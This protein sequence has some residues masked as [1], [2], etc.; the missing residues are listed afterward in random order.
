MKRRRYLLETNIISNLA[1]Q[2][3]GNV[4]QRIQEVGVKQIAI[5]IIVACEVRFGV[6]KS[7][8]TRLAERLDL[9]LGEIEQLPFAPPADVHYAEIRWQ[10]ERT[11]KPIGRNDLLIAAHARA[12]G[13]VLVTDNEQELTRV[14]QLTV[15][16]WLRAREP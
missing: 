14:P 1:R 16:N 15:E 13:F 8:S 3:Q 5:S 6:A 9:I 10:L 4:A 12:L 7:G 2:P 11:G